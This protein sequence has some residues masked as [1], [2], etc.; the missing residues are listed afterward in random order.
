MASEF[1]SL[2]VESDEH[3]ALE[4]I[5]LHGTTL[6]LYRADASSVTEART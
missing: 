2:Y 3:N 4:L 5:V 6:G 1:V